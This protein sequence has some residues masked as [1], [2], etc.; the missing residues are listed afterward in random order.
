MAVALIADPSKSLCNV[1]K[2][3]LVK[4]GFVC[5]TAHNTEDVLY[6]AQ[7]FGINMLVIN[8]DLRGLINVHDAIKKLKKEFPKLFVVLT[9]GKAYASS[10]LSRIILP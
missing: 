9:S 6:N 5:V 3:S 2:D 7:K 10:Y 4:K 1:F 8:V